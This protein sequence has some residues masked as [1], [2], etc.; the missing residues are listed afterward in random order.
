[1]TQAPSG[2]V[3]IVDDEPEIVSLLTQLLD[4]QGYEAVGTTRA[5]EALTLLRDSEFDIL[6]TDLMMPQV[7]GIA[8]LRAGL[9]ADPNLVGIVVTG[10][11]SVETAVDAMKVGAFDYLLKPFRLTEILPILARA[12]AVRRLRV[13]NIQLRE[14]VAIFEKA[15]VPLLSVRYTL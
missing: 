3:L 7:D 4:G 12:R 6:L 13:E 11:G 9:E 14:T 2:R 1:M 5:S 8:L 10:Q 15:P